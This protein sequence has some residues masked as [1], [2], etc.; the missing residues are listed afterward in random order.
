MNCSVLNLPD[1]LGKFSGGIQIICRRSVVNP[2]GLDSSGKVQLLCFVHLPVKIVGKTNYFL[3]YC[4]CYFKKG[5]GFSFFFRDP[6]P[7]PSDDPIR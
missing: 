7:D 5:N 2:A 1:V 4:S 3:Y 6:I